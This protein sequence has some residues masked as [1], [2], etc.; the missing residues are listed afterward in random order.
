MTTGKKVAIGCLGSLI[1]A[2]IIGYL[3]LQWAKQKVVSV[4]AEGAQVVVVDEIKKSPLPSDQ[5]KAFIAAVD[6][7]LGKISNGE[8]EFTFSGTLKDKK[9]AVN[10]ISSAL[11]NA[12]NKL[13]IDAA[14]KEIIGVQIDRL[15]KAYG[16]DQI[17]DKQF[18]DVVTKLFEGQF[19]TLLAIWAAEANY[20]YGSGLTQVE[21]DDAHI[22]LGRLSQGLKSGKLS[23]QDLEKLTDPYTQTNQNGD[24][25]IKGSLTDDEV[26]KLLMSALKLLED[27]Q[28]S[29]DPLQFKIGQEL[30]ESLDSSGVP[31]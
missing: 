6:E 19:G 16:D 15:G 29:E 23:N 18:S 1:L 7:I 28:V 2:V 24:K 31:E 8:I 25:V 21:K 4:I 20:I 12:V 13:E 3:V 26:R 27:K 22:I 5:K 11:K 17:T 10:I 14:Q 30:K 9:K